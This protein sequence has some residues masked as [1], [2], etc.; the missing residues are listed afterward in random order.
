MIKIFSF[1]FNESGFIE[2]QY[3]SF[4]KH[5]KNEFSFTCVDNST[6][7]S[8]KNDL[9]KFCDSNNLSYY[10]CNN[11]GY[12]FGSI[13]HSRALNATI[14]NLLDPNQMSF[15]VDHDVYAI[16]DIDIET[17]CKGYHFS[18]CRQ[19]REYISYLHPGYLII[20]TPIIP[21]ISLLDMSPTSIDGINVDTGGLIHTFTQ[22]N[23]YKINY[24]TFTYDKYDIEVIHNSLIH[25]VA[26][27]NWNNNPLYEEKLLYFNSLVTHDKL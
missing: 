3:K 10:D 20:N 12:G 2:T 25:F 22:T 7:N 5:V 26:G 1:T 9:K 6:D 18:G 27:S 23:N 8:I 17:L 13:S 11:D 15:F 19:V 21:N 24:L 4:K 16:N 14:R